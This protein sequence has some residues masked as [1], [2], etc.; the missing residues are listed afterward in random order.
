MEAKTN[1][2]ETIIGYEFE[3]RF[4]LWEALQAAGSGVVSA[5]G[6]R[7]IDGNKTLAMVGDTVLKLVLI[8]DMYQGG[9][10]RGQIQSTVSYVGAN[11]NLSAVGLA[12]GLSTV[13]NAH[14][15]QFGPVGPVTVASTV[16]AILGAVWYD[17]GKDL[18]AVRR[19]MQTLELRG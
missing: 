14:P 18:G 16:E 5:G 9:H 2:A 7:F 15:G 11:A 1:A 3:D 10:S 12:S 8:E 6:H 19:V 4:L 17:S 13:I